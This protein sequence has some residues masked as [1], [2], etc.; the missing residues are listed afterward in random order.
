MIVERPRTA[1]AGRS[2]PHVSDLKLLLIEG[3]LIATAFATAAFIFFLAGG[4]L[5]PGNLAVFAMGMDV[6]A[7]PWA[8]IRFLRT[9]R[10]TD[11]APRR[12]QPLPS[13]RLQVMTSPKPVCERDHDA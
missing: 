3:L 8:G 9:A 5:L 1:G 13:Q 12:G 6:V 11:A 7:L 4:H 2:S 10:R